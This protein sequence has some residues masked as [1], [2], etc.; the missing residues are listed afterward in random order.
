MPGEEEK[1]EQ[2]AMLRCPFPL[3]GQRLAVSGL[4][5][6]IS[7]AV[8]D[9][10]LSDGQTGS[11]LLRPD[12]PGWE[13]PPRGSGR[14]VFWQYLRLGVSHIL[15][16]WDHLLFLLLLVLVLGRPRPVLLAECAFTVSHSLSYTATALDWIR[17]SA[18]AAEACIALSLIL[19]SLD[20]ERGRLSPISAWQGAGAALVFGLVHG[21]GFAG[22]L[23]E[24]GIPDQ[25][26]LP[27]LVGFAAGVELGQVTFLVAPLTVAWLLGR[28]RVW[29]RFA[30]G[31]AYAAGTLSTYWFLERLWL[32]VER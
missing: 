19:L 21:L 2:L 14:S 17:V 28:T 22:G 4:G 31:S 29:P 24:I 26:V 27:A 18:P 6:L 32:C 1:L 30:V 13:I 10:L 15:T 12:A 3:A 9:V 16:G 5:P 25:E 11:H 23:R 8:L 7:E 20:V